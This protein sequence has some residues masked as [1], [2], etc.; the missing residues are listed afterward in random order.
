MNYDD[1]VAAEPAR[2][3]GAVEFGADWRAGRDGRLAGLRWSPG[4][5]EM[6]VVSP[7]PRPGAAEVEVVGHFRER[8]HV[9][10]AMAGWRD[11]MD[12]L[13]GLRWVRDRSWSDPGVGLPDPPPGAV[14]ALPAEAL[15]RVVG[16]YVADTGQALPDVA[17]DL[18]LDADYLGNV[19]NGALREVD[20][21]TVRRLSDTL[22][23]APEDIWGGE[24][25]AS[26][27]WVYGDLSP[28]D[29]EWAP[30]A[31]PEPAFPRWQP[32]PAAEPPGLDW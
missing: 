22:A 2:E 6:Y 19:M 14:V 29:L 4:T 12:Q 15:R 9:D 17:V 23:L 31:P 10:R 11:H 25:G 13:D 18:G 7:G 27:G 24:A 3:V 20:A 28:A 32:P 8:D 30:P 1:F 26:I 16:S 21:Y 5:G